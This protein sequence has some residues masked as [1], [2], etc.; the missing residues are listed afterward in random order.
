MLLNSSLIDTIAP[1]PVLLYTDFA[2]TT[3]FLGRINTN[4]TLADGICARYGVLNYSRR[5]AVALCCSKLS[6]FNDSSQLQHN[7]ISRCLQVTSSCVH[8]GLA[9]CLSDNIFLFSMWTSWGEEKMNAYSHAKNIV[10]NR[11]AM[12]LCVKIPSSKGIVL[13]RWTRIKRLIITES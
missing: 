12:L 2:Q 13:A 10:Q 11:L 8:E 3:L 4:A 1:V 9:V 5:D 6:I 7:Q